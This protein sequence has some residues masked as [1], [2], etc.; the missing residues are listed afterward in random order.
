MYKEG[1]KKEKPASAGFFIFENKLQFAYNE[2]TSLG[3]SRCS[4]TEQVMVNI[5]ALNRAWSS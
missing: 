2:N 3:S 4:A 1:V 5:F